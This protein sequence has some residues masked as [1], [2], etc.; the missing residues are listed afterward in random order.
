MTRADSLASIE[1][2]SPEWKALRCGRVTAS[3]VAD[4]IAKNRDG[5]TPAAS[6]A[7]Y[8]AALVLERM[9]GD[10]QDIFQ[11]PAMLWGIEN[12]AAACDAYAEQNLVGL[13]QIGFVEHPTIAMAGASPDRL[14]GPDGLV[15]A[16]CPQPAAHL[17]TLLSKTVPAKYRTQILWQLACMPERKWCDFI[18]YHP[19]FP[20]PMRLFTQRIE[21]DDAAIAELEEEVRKFIAEVDE[22]E[23]Q[24][25]AEYAEQLE[26]A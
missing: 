9:T 8:K 10:V 25:R 1:Q 16:K 15:E 3:K 12:E 18:S 23:A 21:R 5:K 7:N 11:T 6:R 22:T 13:T 26:A 19:S 24:L 2:G 14:V 17:E 20:E 4:V